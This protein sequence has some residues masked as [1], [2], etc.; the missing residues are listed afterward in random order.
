VI[1][2]AVGLGVVIAY[3][4]GERW[5]LHR[6]SPCVPVLAGNPHRGAELFASRGCSACHHLYGTGPAIG[7]DLAKPQPEGWRPVRAVAAMWSH[8]PQM[9]RKLIEAR[10]GLAHMSERD[11]LDLFAFI[12]MLQY[13]D[14]PGDVSKGE[15]LFVSKSCANCHD[16]GSGKKIGPDLAKLDADTPILWAQR[17]WNH[18]HAMSTLATKDGTPWPTFKGKEMADLLAYVRSIAQGS[19]REARLL[20]A[21]PETGQQLFVTKGCVVCHA[22]DARGGNVGPDLGPRHLI[23]ATMIELAALMWNHAPRMAEMMKAR[24]LAQPKFEEQEMADLIAFLQQVHYSEPQ[25]NADTGRRIFETKGC[26]TC[27]GA[28]ARGGKSGPDLLGAKAPYCASKMFYAIWSHGAQMHRK[29]EEA[30][31]PWPTFEE[32]EMVDLISFL[33]HN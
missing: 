24:G 21:H 8:S 7:P 6:A 23:P 11:V 12:A 33:N 26:A 2:V 30:G 5:Y 25:G 1:V 31:I 10:M 18:S 20:P 19:R 16:P 29:M 28:D 14:E 32:Q 22:I 13:M 3:S 27:H 15:E 4:V 9:W 17:M